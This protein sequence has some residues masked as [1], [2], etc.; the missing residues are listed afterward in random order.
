[1]KTE[2]LGNSKI[3]NLIFKPAGMVMESRLRH[4]IYNPVKTLRGAGI[5]SGQTILEVGSGT[6]FFTIPAAHWKKGRMINNA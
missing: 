6:G 4:W 1:M 2:D 3:L 5:K